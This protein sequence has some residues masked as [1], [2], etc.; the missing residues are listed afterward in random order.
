MTLARVNCQTGLRGPHSPLGPAM[1]LL[2][3]ISGRPVEF[4]KERIAIPEIR[5]LGTYGIE[6]VHDG[7]RRIDPGAK[8]WL[9]NVS[10]A[11]ALRNLL[12]RA[13]GVRVEEK[14][15]SV[16]VH[17]RQAPDH[18][19]A[20][21]QVHRATTRIAAEIGL[22]LEAGELRRKNCSPRSTWTRGRLSS[23]FSPLRISTVA[24][25][26][27]DVG[28]IPALRAVRGAGGYALVVDHGQETDPLL[29]ELAD[30]AFAGTDGFAA[31]LAELARAA[32][33]AGQ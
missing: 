11:T 5:L 4:L 25:A 7:I 16:A 6:Q 21:G 24:Y 9:S 18:R 12:R 29:L 23:G 30:Q 1:G 26:G 32:G 3:V 8:K 27:D 17:W 28:D 22:R 2:A 19:A 13:E 33:T 15:V 10:E 31:W 14:S 20:A